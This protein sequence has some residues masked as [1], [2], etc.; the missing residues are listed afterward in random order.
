M[1]QSRGK[2][3]IPNIDVFGPYRMPRK[4][5]EYGLNEYNQA[6][7]C[8]TG[9]TCDGRMERDADALWRAD[10]G[11]AVVNSYPIKLRIY[12]GYDETTVWQEFGEMKFASRDEIPEI[13]G[14][15]D[16][17]KPRWVTTRYVPWTS[18][19]A[20][21]QQWG[22]S[23]VRQGE[24]SGTITHELGHSVFSVGDNN[25]NPYATPY[26]RVGTGPWDMMD[27]G[28]FNGPGGPHRRWVVPAAEGA[29]MPAGL[30]L[31]NRLAMEVMSVEKVARVSRNALAQSGPV[32]L[33]IAAR[34][35]EPPAGSWAGLSVRLDGDA[36]QDKTPVCDR[37]ADP[38][39][40]G[41]PRLQRLL[42][43]G[44]A[45]H[46]LRLVHARQRRVAG[47]EQGSADELVRL[48]L[49]RVGD[50]RPS[51]RH[52]APRLREGK[53]RARHAYGRRLPAIER[54]A[55]P[56]RPPLRQ[57]L[58]VEGRA[59]PPALLRDRS[60]RRRPGRAVVHRRRPITRRRRRAG[61]RRHRAGTGA[62]AAE[63]PAP[64]VTA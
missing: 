60:P 31:R 27:R 49:S 5:F 50:R 1:E 39:C 14:N 63:W 24:S 51:R 32:V 21:A 47:K 23:S 46:R 6:S 48:R 7:G 52:E 9:Y 57:L 11:D 28:S 43:R 41:D 18:W 59:E 34:A 12:A 25:N 54:R 37:N 35:V 56:R 61:P 22:L 17:S 58:R 33:T 19:L 10:A 29:A 20:G 30:M 36:P 55:L 38:L 53:R 44:R 26:R 62:A 13:W 45:A 40:A 4:L 8:P 2:V 15:P 3:G 42:G 16:K 64:R